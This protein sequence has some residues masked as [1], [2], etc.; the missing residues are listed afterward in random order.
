CLPRR[1]AGLR[2]GAAAARA[3]AGDG[4]PAGAAPDRSAGAA[5]AGNAGHWL[6]RMLCRRD[7]PLGCGG[8][9]G[10]VS[11]CSGHPLPPARPRQCGD[12]MFQAVP[13]LR[14]NARLAQAARQHSKD[15]ARRRYF[16]HEGPDGS[17]LAGRVRAQQYRWRHLGE[18]IAA[19]HGSAAQVVRSWLASPGHCTNIMSPR[20]TEMGAAYVYDAASETGIYWTQVFGTPR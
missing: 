9:E 8:C 12:T 1:S 11:L 5:A 20:F 3:T 6:S 7:P 2:R 16:A 14:W 18:N 17:T 10:S 19:G 13:P 4:R 15:M